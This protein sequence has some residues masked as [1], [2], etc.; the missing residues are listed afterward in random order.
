VAIPGARLRGPAARL[1][2]AGGRPVEPDVLI[3]A[4]WSDDPPAGPAHALQSLV[5]RL[6]RIL[7][8][9]GSVVQVVGGYRLEVAAADVDVLRFEQLT[10]TG[11][12][13]LRAG[14]PIAAA[15]LLG[16]AAALWGEHPGAEPPVVAAVA[17]AVA[18]RLAHIS[19]EAVVDLADAETALGRA[20]AAADRLTAVLAEQPVHE[21]AA[22]LLM[23][24][25]AAEDARRPATAGRR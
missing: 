7:G 4:I 21:R 22:A 2:L 19:I 10:T 13:R 23:D 3:D 9:P 25:L 5:S 17:P 1:A 16:E 6:R 14:D 24:A 15:A 8:S 20:D 18:T 12:H 11:R